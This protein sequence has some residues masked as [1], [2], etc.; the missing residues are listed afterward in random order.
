MTEINLA[1]T[2]GKAKVRAHQLCKQQSTDSLTRHRHILVRV[3][4]VPVVTVSRIDA[5]LEAPSLVR[6]FTFFHVLLEVV[7]L[8]CVCRFKCVV[9]CLLSLFRSGMASFSTCLN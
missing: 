7:L 5:E 6:N 1:P 9:P 4:E 2:T 8:V 3:Q